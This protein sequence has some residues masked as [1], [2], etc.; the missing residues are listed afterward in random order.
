MIDVGNVTTYT[1]SNL[2][3]GAY[4]FAVTAYDSQNIESGYSNE[5]SGT[6]Q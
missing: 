3:S 1:I 5:V 4:Y 2:V 6:I